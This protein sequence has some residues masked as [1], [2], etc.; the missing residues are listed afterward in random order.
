MNVHCMRTTL[1]FPHTMKKHTGHWWQN[2]FSFSSS[3]S[4]SSAKSTS[5][6][7]LIAGRYAFKPSLFSSRRVRSSRLLARAKKLRDVE[8]SRGTPASSF[9]D[10]P[11]RLA[12]GA[13]S[14]AAAAP[15]SPHPLPLPELQTLLRREAKSASDRASLNNVPLPSPREPAHQ[16]DNVAEEKENDKSDCLNGVLNNDSSSSSNAAER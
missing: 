12:T 2:A 10:S 8:F 11:A 6:D 1:S 7:S 3:S 4:S 9:D 5:D 14:P 13:L 16:R 15:P